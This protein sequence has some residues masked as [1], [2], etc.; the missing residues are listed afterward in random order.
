MPPEKPKMSNRRTFLKTVGVG[1]IAV[2]LAGCVG[3]DDG[4]SDDGTT[5]DEPSSGHDFGGD[6]MTILFNLGDIA[7]AHKE[8]VVP[9]VEEKY[10]VTVQSDT[11]VTSKMVQ[12]TQGDDPPDVIQ[13]D[14]I[15][16]EKLN[17]DDSL[18][19]I[20]EYEDLVPRWDAIHPNAKHYDGAGVSWFFDEVAPYINTDMWDEKPESWSGVFEGGE[21]IGTHPFTWT[22]GP[23]TLLMA[24]AIVTG[25]P[26]NSSDFTQ[27][28]IDKGFDYLEEH[29][30]PNLA[31]VFANVVQP[32]QALLS[33]EI[34]T[35]L[36]MW[37]YHHVN[38]V[39]RFDNIEILRRR[40]PNGVP[41][42]NSMAVPEGSEMTEAAMLYINEAMKAEVQEDISGLM[43]T[44]VVV[45][46]AEMSDKAKNYDSPTYD[47]IDDIQWPDF[48]FVWEN[49]DEWTE[50]WNE[51][52]S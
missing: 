21:A 22:N 12:E 43:G 38:I 17:H 27:D 16:V 36:M 32:E 48:R 30:A 44:G 4:S 51:I 50:R 45:E 33:D 40:E 41:A 28:D 2:S 13:P 8:F 6:T 46:D 18:T 19:N 35:A 25:K 37:G 29:L 5:T 34:D 10:N 31:G 52:T 1:S 14:T 9:R 42:A 24:T 7:R 20:T 11:V 49:R 39:P 15:G 26:F 47:Q 3:D 23:Y